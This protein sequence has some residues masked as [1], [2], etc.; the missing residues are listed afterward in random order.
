NLLNSLAAILANGVQWGLQQAG[1]SSAGQFIFLGLTSIAAAWYAMKLLPSNVLRV[2]LKMVLRI[3]YRIRVMGEMNVPENGGAL[4]ISNHVSWVD[5][6]IIG[7]A[8]PRDVRFVA[9]EEFFR[10]RGVGWFLRVF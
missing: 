4:M 7:A 8:C 1:L 6:L 10:L 3:I 2:I 9:A 5:A